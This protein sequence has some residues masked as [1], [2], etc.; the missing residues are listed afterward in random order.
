MPPM[1]GRSATMEIQ[2][3]WPIMERRGPQIGEAEVAAFE[4]RLGSTLPDDYRRFLLEVNGG[5]PSEENARHPYDIVNSLFSLADK[6]H[7]SRDLETR[8]TWARTHKLIPHCSSAASM[9]LASCSPSPAPIA[10]RCG[11]RT[12]SILAPTTRIRGSCGTTGAT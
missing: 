12:L 8:A 5:R 6:D 3:S 11:V 4:Q 7:E 2:A 10:A 9:A 1:L